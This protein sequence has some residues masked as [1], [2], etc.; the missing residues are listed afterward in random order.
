MNIL[1]KLGRRFLMKRGYSVSRSPAVDTGDYALASYTAADGSFDYAKYVSVQTAGNRAKINNVWADKATIG[2]ICDYLTSSGVSP[3]QGLCHGSRNGAEVNW[4]R[5]I[6]GCEVVGTDISDTAEEFGLVQWDFHKKRDDWR[7]RFDF[8]YTNSHD[9]AHDPKIAFDTWVDQLAPG[10]KLFIEHTMAHS[11]SGVTD[12]DPFG[13]DPRIFPY[14][15]LGF[16]GGRYAVTDMI[17]PKHL[18]IAP[19]E[20]LQIWVFVIEARA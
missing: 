19:N 15:I 1:E 13:V 6:L 8:V 3:K 4:F 2:L 14:V 20:K 10:G 17:R 11:P 9:H 12:L 7:G 5:E 16:A 18:K